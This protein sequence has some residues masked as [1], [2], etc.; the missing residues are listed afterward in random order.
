VIKIE[1]GWRGFSEIDRVTYDVDK[2]N[3]H[4]LEN[5]LKKAGTYIR[6][7]PPDKQPVGPDGNR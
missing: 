4:Q 3:L 2:T 6:T 1:K 7:V 5:L